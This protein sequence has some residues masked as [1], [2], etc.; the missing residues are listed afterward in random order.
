MLVRPEG[1]QVEHERLVAPREDLEEIG[2][3]VV[4]EVL[5]PRG[6]LGYFEQDAGREHALLLEAFQVDGLD[7]GQAGDRRHVLGD[8]LVGD[9]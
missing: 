4:G 9:V 6:G 3:H 5:T 7:A 1:G 2:A 8:L